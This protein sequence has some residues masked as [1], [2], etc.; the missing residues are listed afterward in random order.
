MGCVGL[1]N[2]KC[3]QRLRN[4]DH[5]HHH[6]E[7]KTVPEQLFTHPD[8]CRIHIAQPSFCVVLF[9]DHCVIC[10]SVITASDCIFT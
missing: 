2:V 7:L 10:P 4:V 8:F 5:K 3:K 9:V 1:Y 6:V